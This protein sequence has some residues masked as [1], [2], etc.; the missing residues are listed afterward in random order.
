MTRL[1]NIGSVLILHVCF[2]HGFLG[3]YLGFWPFDKHIPLFILYAIFKP[4]VAR[5]SHVSNNN[6][7]FVKLKS[8]AYNICN[9]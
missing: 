4:C 5:L 2:V 1:I 7:V 9:V 6:G 8:F 3:L